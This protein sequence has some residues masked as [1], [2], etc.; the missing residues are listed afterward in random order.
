MII[1]FLLIKIITLRWRRGSSVPSAAPV[2]HTTR[3]TQ[4]V[5]SAAVP[6]VPS[7]AP[8]PHKTRHTH[9][10]Q[11]QQHTRREPL[12]LEARA[13]ASGASASAARSTPSEATHSISAPEA[14]LPERLQ[15][16]AGVAVFAS[17]RCG[18]SQ[19]PALSTQDTHHTHRHIRHTLGTCPTKQGP[20]TP[21]GYWFGKTSES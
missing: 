20:A 5:P 18:A 9:S 7:A 11:R 14:C 3:H 13:K 2:Q 16:Q 1:I 15:A 10:Q 6:R 12:R 19:A 4:H 21:F 8:V 17:R